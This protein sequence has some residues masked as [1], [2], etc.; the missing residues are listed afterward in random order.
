MSAVE[1]ER[2]KVQFATAGVHFVQL[3]DRLAVHAQRALSN[4]HAFRPS[5]G[6]GGVN[7]IGQALLVNIADRGSIAVETAI[8]LI[9]FQ[10]PHAVRRR[11]RR[12]QAGLRQQQ[13]HARIFDHVRQALGRIIDVQRHVRRTALEH[14]EEAHQ[15][16]Q[17]TRQCHADHHFR[18]GA[19]GDQALRESIGL[20]LQL[21][22]AQAF[23]GA[24]HCDR[25]GLLLRMTADQLRQQARLMA[26]RRL[27]TPGL[28]RLPLFG[29]QTLQV[30]QPLIRR[31][32]HRREGVFQGQANALHR[33]GAEVAAQVQVLD[34]QLVAERHRKVHR[35]VGHAV[36]DGFAEGQLG[37]GFF[38]QALVDREVFEHHD[39]VEQRLTTEV[40]PA[41]HIGQRCLGIIPNVEVVGL[42]FA[43]PVG[44]TLIGLWGLNDRQ[45][46]DEQAEHVA[47]VRQTFR[48]PRYGGAEGHRLL[49]GV[50][51]Q[52]QQPRALDQCVGG[53][54][55]VAAELQQACGLR[56]VPI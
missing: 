38:L 50:A 19:V 39:A 7:Q 53:D 11:Q 52:Q 31:G 17:R 54:A 49:T 28:R 36:A 3:G 24:L 23:A 48:A 35:H 9:D 33:R 14:G 25:V 6:T 27:G 34:R 41:L 42:Q 55:Q 22:V 20:P 46:V 8:E 18:T 13:G 30:A 56:L 29:G 43:Q 47:D 2:H 40:R 32:H 26:V 16:F 21:C 10:T 1:G 15:H 37:V 4:G 51:L 12:A 45:G 44:Q 5:G